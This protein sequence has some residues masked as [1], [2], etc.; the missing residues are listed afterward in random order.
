MTGD[1]KRILLGHIV[2]AHGIRGEVLVKCYTAEPR[3]I[4][5][6]GTLSDE[7]GTRSFTLRVMHISNKGTVVRIAGIADRNAAEKLKGVGL[8]AARDRLPDAGDETFYHVDLIG[9]AAVDAS[10]KTLGTVISVQNFGAGDL[11]EIE[12]AGTDRTEFI[13]FQS[14]TVPKVDIAG[15][16]LTVILPDAGEA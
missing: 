1:G 4:A 5:D 11:I 14:A 16:R 8:Y 13:P 9:L 3:A 7:S 10:G 12:F 15:G 2:G 6:Y